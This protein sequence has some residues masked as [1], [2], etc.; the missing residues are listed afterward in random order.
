M[1]S[2]G[3]WLA[4]IA[5]FAALRSREAMPGSLPIASGMPSHMTS[6]ASKSRPPICDYTHEFAAEN[7]PV[8]AFHEASHS[9]SDDDLPLEPT[10]ARLDGFREGKLIFASDASL[11]IP[12]TLDAAVDAFMDLMRDASERGFIDGRT[13]TIS[14]LSRFYCDLAAKFVWPPVAANRLST[15]LETKGFRKSL[16]RERKAGKDKK[17][18][19]FVITPKRS[20]P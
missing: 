20:E 9:T 5:P 10:G 7:R 16:I 11:P 13:M 14:D 1:I 2:I 17:T 18:V 6:K 4:T 15:L 12:Y 19:A 8:E 3:G